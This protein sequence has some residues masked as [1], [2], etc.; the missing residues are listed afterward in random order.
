MDLRT[1]SFATGNEAFLAVPVIAGA[2]Q[3][4]A[5]TALISP[6]IPNVRDV[7]P[8]AAGAT[9]LTLQI[10]RAG[11]LKSVSAGAS[12]LTLPTTATLGWTP[13][14]GKALYFDYWRCGLGGLFINPVIGSG[15]AGVTIIWNDFDPQFLPQYHTPGRLTYAGVSATNGNDVWVA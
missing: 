10:I 9:T 2:S 11:I 14:A 15:A 12:T 5:N 3:G 1:A 6:T 13:S 7:F 8:L 4:A